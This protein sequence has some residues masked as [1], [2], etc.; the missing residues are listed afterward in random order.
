[1]PLASPGGGNPEGGCVLQPKVAVLS[2]LGNY[3]GLRSNP[4]GVATFTVSK[5]SFAHCRAG[6]NTEWDERYMWVRAI[7]PLGLGVAIRFSQGSRVQQPWAERQN[8]FGVKMKMPNSSHQF[9]D[10]TTSL[11]S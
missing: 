3:G 2:Y 6:T 8:P 10:G 5:M 7:T 4:E 1:M 9:V 11:I